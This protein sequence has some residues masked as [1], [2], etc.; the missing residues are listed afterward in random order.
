M[1]FT[2]ALPCESTET[3]IAPKEPERPLEEE[4]DER[5]DPSRR[6]RFVVSGRS[7][8]SRIIGIVLA[9][10]GVGNGR[11]GRGRRNAP[12]R[13]IGSFFSLEDCFGQFLLLF[14]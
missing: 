1:C 12:R 5:G 6:G 7:L 3:G 9:R 10:E 2:D 13:R 11:R 8:G 4:D 14:F